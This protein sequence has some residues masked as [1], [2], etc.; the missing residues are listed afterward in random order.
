MRV[1]AGL[2]C[3]LFFGAVSWAEDL[4]FEIPPAE[5]QKETLELSGQLDARYSLI[6]SRNSSVLYALQYYNRPLS[7]VLS[8]Y[9]ADFYL[10]GDYHTGDVGV[11]LKTYSGYY[12]SN[13]ANIDLY[14]LYGNASITGNSFLLLGQKM[15][16]WGKGYAF[17]PVGFVNPKKDPENPDQPQSGLLSM[18]YQYT[19]SFTRGAL[20]NIS[21]DLILLPSA[22]TI[23]GK[24]AEAENTDIAGKIYLLLWN[25]D[26][27]LMGY[28]SRVNPEKYGFDF[29]RNVIPSLEI[30][31]EYSRFTNLPRYYL[32]NDSLRTENIDGSSYLFG[33]RWLNSWNITTIGEYYRNEAGLSKA[34]FDEYYGFLANAVVSGNN[35]AASGAL[36]TSK[37]YF[38]NPNLMQEYLYLKA[39]WQ[40]PFNWLYFTP[41]VQVLY[42]LADHSYS[43]GFPVS[44]KPITNLEFVFWPAV[45]AGGENSEYGSKQ[46][47][48][49]LDLWATF[50]F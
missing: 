23:N 38:S 5:T 32:L 31:G 17:N 20:N 48:S 29:S 33:F 22:N 21:L 19:K 27:D 40:E 50:Y 14:E 13:Q 37:T 28:Y 43:A 3:F 4:S 42:N 39:S 34:E 35:V 45:F 30:H 26:I 47:E 41:A 9:R 1:L 6:K 11:H 12:G 10:N 36:N 18:N 7:D 8:S 44:Y 24:V 46:Y 16:N 49:K 15:Y 2:L 25:T